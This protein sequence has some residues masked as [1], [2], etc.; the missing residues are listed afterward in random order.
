MQRLLDPEIQAFIHAH[1]ESDVAALGLKKPPH[2]DWPYPLILDQIKSRQKAKI[3]MPSWLL[4]DGIIFPPPNLIEQASSSAAAKYKSSLVKGS[5]FADLT[6]GTGADF[7]AFLENFSSGIAIE[8]DTKAKEILAHNLKIFCTKSFEIIN[9]AAENHIGHLP[10]CDL[11]YL[12]PQRR[13]NRGKSLFRLQD[14]SP[15]VLELLPTLRKKSDVTMIKTSPVLDIGQTVRDLETV[16]QVHVVEWRGECRE[17]LYILKNN[18]DETTIIPVIIDNDGKPLAKFSF[19]RRQE[20]DSVSQFSE[21]L[22]YLFE[23]SPAFQK[24]GCYKFIGEHYGL[25]KLHPHT[26]LYTSAQPCP[27]FPGRAFEILGTYN[28]GGKNLP[29]TT[30]NLT[31]RN[32]PSQTEDLRKK[33]SL[34]DG[35]NDYIFACTLADERKALLHAVKT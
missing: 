30:A 12:D 20:A 15:D 28:A 17:V 31:V 5:I 13:N 34:K 27:G 16:A 11:V 26:H 7:L 33:L 25:K 32:F 21:P 18:P 3:K 2:A 4:A 24:S 29:I 6:A 1:A 23:P 8:Q 9:T 35:G 19:T 10:H 22:K 14:C